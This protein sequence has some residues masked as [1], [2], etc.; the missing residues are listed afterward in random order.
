MVVVDL[1]EIL[2]AHT[3][4][5]ITLMKRRT[6]PP[7]LLRSIKVKQRRI[8]SFHF[9]S[10]SSLSFLPSYTGLINYR[11]IGGSIERDCDDGSESEDETTGRG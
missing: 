10:S 7:S 4:H 1:V 8:T 3:S 11:R 2:S 6:L 9:T 5:S